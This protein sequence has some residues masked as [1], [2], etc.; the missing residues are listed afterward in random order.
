MASSPATTGIARRRNNLRRGIIAALV[1]L[2]LGLFTVYFRESDDGALHGAQS[3]AASVISPVQEVATRA[4]EPFRDAWGWASSLKDARDRSASLETEVDRLR[5]EVVFSDVQA[6]RL[7]ELEKLLGVE[8]LVDA[9]KD[10]GGYEAKTSSVVTR[11]I[12]P[13]WRSAR[14]GIGSSDGVMRNSPVLAGSEQGAALVGI[15]TNV[16]SRSA[17]V[18]F[19]TDG[20]TEVG[21]RIPDAGPYFGLLS[22][23]TPGQ[24]QLSGIPKEAAVKTGQAVVTGG[25]G[26]KG[27]QSPY[28]PGVPVGVVTSVGPQEVDVDRTVQVTPYVD[29]RTLSY[30]T[31][32]IPRSPE[33]IARAKG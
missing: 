7:D 29:P 3:T 2:C 5:G 13:W 11:S 1:I 30:M 17:D 25:F 31:V 21:G 24:L 26:V 23:I 9:S 33:A 12:S 19:V 10:L 15:V 32:L 22:S 6:Q 20:R 18:S 27:L 28:P 14:V 16:S 8:K 4:V